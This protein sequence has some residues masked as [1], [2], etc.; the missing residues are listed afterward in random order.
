MAPGPFTRPVLQV[1]QGRKRQ[2][3]ARLPLPAQGL[4]LPCTYLIGVPGRR[5][6]GAIEKADGASS[7]AA[8]AAI[9]GISQDLQQQKVGLEV[10]Q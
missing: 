1:Q 10:K 6:L 2:L 9:D 4:P 3:P 8:C 7:A 5:G